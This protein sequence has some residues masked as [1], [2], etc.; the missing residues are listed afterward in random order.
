MIH[1]WGRLPSEF[2]LCDPED[3]LSLMAAYS[4]TVSKMRAYED[5]RQ[6]QA[7]NRATGK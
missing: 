4:V 7:M 5:Y 6:A 1:D 3:D 2:G